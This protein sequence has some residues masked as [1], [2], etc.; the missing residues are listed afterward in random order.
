MADGGRARALCLP[1]APAEGSINGSGHPWAAA[2][3]VPAI[4]EE[5]TT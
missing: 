2:F 3:S 4:A 5:H 1:G